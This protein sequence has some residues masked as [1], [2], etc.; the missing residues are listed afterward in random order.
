MADKKEA[1]EE[2]SE[3]ELDQIIQDM[4]AAEQSEAAS[5]TLEEEVEEAASY[6]RGSR[7]SSEDRSVSLELTGVVN[8]RLSF[9]DGE[10]TIDL[11]CSEDELVCRTADGAEFRI[12]TAGHGRARKAA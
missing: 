12:P 8:L 9:R 1:V 4:S 11:S 10:R 3:D 7:E 2:I 6:K 5:S